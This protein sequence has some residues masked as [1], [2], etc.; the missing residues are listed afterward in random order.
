MP[1]SESL[2]DVVK[3]PRDEKAPVPVEPRHDVRAEGIF[4][5]EV[6][7][8]KAADVPNDAQRVLIDREDVVE[9]VL[10][11]PDDVPEG[12]EI[13]PEN[14]PEIHLLESMVG[15]AGK[16]QDSQEGLVV[17]RVVSEGVVDPE[18]RVPEGAKKTRR[19]ALQFHVLGKDE[20]GL[21]HGARTLLKEFRIVN[22]HFVAA[23]RKARRDRKNLGARHVAEK[24]VG[25]RIELQLRHLNDLLGVS[26]VCLHEAFRCAHGAR[27]QPA[28]ALRER[29]LQV[30][31]Q[32]V[33]VAFCAKVQ[34]DAE[35]TEKVV[36][37]VE[38]FHFFFGEEP[39]LRE[40]SKV[41]RDV[42]GLRAPEKDLNVAQAPGTLL[43]VGFERIGGVFVALMAPREFEHLLLKEVL[44]VELGVKA[45]ERTGE[46]CLV[47]AQEALFEVGRRNRHVAR[48]LFEEG[49][50]TSHR[51]AYG[52]AEI[53]EFREKIRNAFAERRIVRKPVLHENEEVDVGIGIELFAPAAA[54]GH[55]GE[56]FAREVIEIGERR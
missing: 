52:E 53:P 23:G 50:F 5:R 37:T 35:V 39:R 17:F 31:D 11:L 21:E 30:E 29:F 28:K 48:S 43:D 26:V 8:R 51:G 38:R 10:H 18:R 27:G 49:R 14:P 32:T 13:A 24:P 3:E 2:S 1:A 19:H 4:V 15:A 46:E 54:H 6:A 42:R 34:V 20:E 55:E 7:S 40:V 45:L 56:A 41:G 25:E 33:F 44:G 16:L 22:V 9:V 36:D 47:A 12:E